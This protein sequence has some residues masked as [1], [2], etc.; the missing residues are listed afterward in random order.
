[1]DLTT[2]ALRHL[3]NGSQAPPL[4]TKT[5]RLTNHKREESSV[6]GQPDYPRHH[7]TGSVIREKRRAAPNPSVILDQ[8]ERLEAINNANQRFVPRVFES[9]SGWRWSGMTPS[10]RR[11]WAAP[12][13][14]WPWWSSPWAGEYS[15]RCS[16]TQQNRKHTN[17]HTHTYTLTHLHTHL[18]GHREHRQTRQ[19]P[20]WTGDKNCT[21]TGMT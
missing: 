11:S 19:K 8:S 1:M 10:S 12:D 13:P 16:R 17:T 5:G 9:W 6:I 3:M 20:E 2:V 14:G 7:Y 15:G 18:T 4:L 21:N